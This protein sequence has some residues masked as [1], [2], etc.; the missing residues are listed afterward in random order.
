[1]KTVKFFF[2]KI[3]QGWMTFAKILGIINTTLLLTVT[4]VIII[5]WISIPRRI[6]FGK[7][8][9]SFWSSLPFKTA[10]EKNY[11]HPF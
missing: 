4:Y 2:K 9:I 6:F 7:Q 5:P 11:F 10:Q 1:M 8:Y 3:Y